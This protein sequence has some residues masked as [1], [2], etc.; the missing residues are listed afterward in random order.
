MNISSSTGPPREQ[1]LRR[2]ASTVKPE[3]PPPE[4]GPAEKGSPAADPPTLWLH[5][6]DSLRCNQY[7]IENPEN[8]LCEGDEAWRRATDGSSGVY[9]VALGDTGLD[10]KGLRAVGFFFCF[11]LL[12]FS[13]IMS[14]VS[15]RKLILSF[16][17]RNGK[18]VYF[19]IAVFSSL[20]I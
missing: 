7:N 3:T 13:G 9:F 6:L 8:R 17:I 20:V 16:F 18:K 10:T 5:S 2:P 15:S 1:N 14:V 4:G 11:S 19:F 12:C